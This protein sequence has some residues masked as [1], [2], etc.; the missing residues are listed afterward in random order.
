MQTEIRNEEEQTRS[1]KFRYK[2]NGIGPCE[3][4]RG[5][6]YSDKSCENMRNLI[7]FSSSIRVRPAVLS[8][9][10]DP[11]EAFKLRVSRAC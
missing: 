8:D 7:E 2:L 3:T 4:Y 9:K 5:E 6:Y 11:M 1:A 10:S